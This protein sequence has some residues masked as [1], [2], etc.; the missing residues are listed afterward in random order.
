MFFL[1]T[2]VSR[3]TYIKMKT[4]MAS[5]RNA[6]RGEKPGPTRFEPRPFVRSE[7]LR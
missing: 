1:F 6:W 3:T 4:M 5:P 7:D 2:A